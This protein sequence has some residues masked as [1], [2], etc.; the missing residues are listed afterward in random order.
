MAW[1]TLLLECATDDTALGEKGKGIF[2]GV[3][4]ARVYRLGIQLRPFRFVVAATSKDK[5]IDEIGPQ[6]R[7]IWSKNCGTAIIML[8]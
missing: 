4:T 6:K 3:S 2:S 5:K 7:Y 1:E 8:I